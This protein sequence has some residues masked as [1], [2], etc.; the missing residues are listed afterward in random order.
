MLELKYRW[1]Q[2]GFMGLWVWWN[3]GGFFRHYDL[4]RTEI[5]RLEDIGPPNAQDMAWKLQIW[6][7]RPA[8]YMDTVEF[9]CELA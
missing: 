2:D 9:A 3:H 5:Q 1:V 6:I 7:L 4:L 8:G